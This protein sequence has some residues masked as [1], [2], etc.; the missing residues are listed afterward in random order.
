[1]K[2]AAKVF[3]AVFSWEKAIEFAFF[4]LRA[5]LNNVVTA[6]L[7]YKGKRFVQLMSAFK[8]TLGEAWVNETP[9]PIDNQVLDE[10]G[11]TVADAA[12]KWNFKLPEV[13]EV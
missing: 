5:V 11:K 1:M 9:T 10:V 2:V 4:V 3:A 12:K 8:D 7:T 6:D 13:P